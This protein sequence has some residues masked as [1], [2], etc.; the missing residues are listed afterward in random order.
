MKKRFDLRVL[1]I[2]ITVHVLAIVLPWFTFTWAG[3]ATFFIMYFV[4]G[5]LG[6]TV[7]YHRMLTHPGFETYFPIR[8]FFTLCGM[9]AGE[10]GPVDW[11]GKHRLHHIHSDKEGDPHS[12]IKGIDYAHLRWMLYKESTEEKKALLR[13]VKDLRKEKFMRICSRPFCYAAWNIAVLVGIGLVG[14]GLWDAFTA[15]SMVVWGGFLRLVWV[16]HSTWLVNSATHRWGYRNYENTDD[17][18]RNTWWVALLTYGE[19]WHN[20][21]H[22]V[23]RAV[24]H[25]QR[26]WELDPSYWVIRTMAFFGLAW[27][28]CKAEYPSGEE[29]ILFRRKRRLKVVEP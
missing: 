1:S 8:W 23:M 12:P 18:S 5:C 29:R 14:Y 27:N 28:V 26:P 13:L 7:C 20:N 15:V 2:L 3:L 4:T 19:G 21:H 25:G 24:N 9:A 22:A 11:A 16:Y 17:N 10:G 6:I